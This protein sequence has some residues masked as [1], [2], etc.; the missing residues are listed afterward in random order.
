MHIPPIAS[1]LG[2]PFLRFTCGASSAA[3]QSKN[4][5]SV[6]SGGWRAAWIELGISWPTLDMSFISFA[7]PAAWPFLMVHRNSCA[8][9]S[10]SRYAVLGS[11]VLPAQTPDGFL[12]V[13]S[14]PVGRARQNMDGNLEHSQELFYFPV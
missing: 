1:P 14:V 6:I 3:T 13:V 12:G 10:R 7:L 8:P 5:P 4:S 11:A 2:L 9:Y